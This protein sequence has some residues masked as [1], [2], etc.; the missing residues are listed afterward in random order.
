MSPFVYKSV[1]PAS[2]CSSAFFFIQQE[3]TSDPVEK[4]LALLSHS[5][6]YGYVSIGNIYFFVDRTICFLVEGYQLFLCFLEEELR[7]GHRDAEHTTH[8]ADAGGDAIHG[9]GLS[10]YLPSLPH[11]FSLQ[12][13]TNSRQ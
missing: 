10:S 3:S 4:F 7:E 8:E 9:L 12:D 13:D 5:W 1:A 11:F 2:R 6:I